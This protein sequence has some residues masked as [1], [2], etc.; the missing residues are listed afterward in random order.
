MACLGFKKLHRHKGNGWAVIEK[1][2]GEI[3]TE[4][5]VTYRRVANYLFA[6]AMRKEPLHPSAEEVAS[7]WLPHPKALLF[8]YPEGESV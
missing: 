8:T 2:G 1:E 7:Q 4:S 5:S 3:N 6:H